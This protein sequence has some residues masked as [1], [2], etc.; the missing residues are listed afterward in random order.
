LKFLKE[1]VS[2][3][4]HVNIMSQYRPMG[5][6]KKFKELSLPLSPE[7]FRKALELGR[8]LGLKLIR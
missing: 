1:E 7:E 8:D 2:P 3:H 5:D 6:A 4:T